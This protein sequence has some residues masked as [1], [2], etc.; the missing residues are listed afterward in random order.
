MAG[1]K[2]MSPLNTPPDGRLPV[3]TIVM[4]RS[5]SE[6]HEVLCRELDRGGQVFYVVPRIEM[7]AT[8]VELLQT[9]L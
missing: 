5:D 7:I 9:L 6:I 4:E 2:A 3:Q 1:I 8:E